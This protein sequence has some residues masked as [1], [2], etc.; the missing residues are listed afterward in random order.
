MPEDDC[1]MPLFMAYPDCKLVQ[2]LPDKGFLESVGHE[3]FPEQ[4]GEILRSDTSG[5]K[6]L[7]SLAEAAARTYQVVASQAEVLHAFQIE[8]LIGQQVTKNRTIGVILP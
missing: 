1:G 3:P 8:L 4:A 7:H 2:F 5:E 6:I